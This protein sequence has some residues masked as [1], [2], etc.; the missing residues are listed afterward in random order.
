[1]DFVSDE[2]G[3]HATDHA[4][5]PHK[6]CNCSPDNAAYQTP[7]LQARFPSCLNASLYLVLSLGTGH[8]LLQAYLAQLLPR[9]RGQHCAAV[10]SGALAAH[11]SYFVQEPGLLRN[12]SGLLQQ[13]ARCRR[14]AMQHFHPM[15]SSCM[16]CR[17]CV[18]P[19]ALVIASDIDLHACKPCHRCCCCTGWQRTT[20][21]PVCWVVRKPFTRWNAWTQR[22][23][24]LVA[25][26]CQL[27]VL[28]GA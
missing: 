2:V 24:T 6:C 20:P 14:L 28:Q 15:L 13:Y 10:G 8:C 12:A 16:C 25:V 23:G 11:F 9:E 1:M 21:A 27:N 22:L 19:A 26:G 5:D 4:T 3:W 17:W 18:A 7:H